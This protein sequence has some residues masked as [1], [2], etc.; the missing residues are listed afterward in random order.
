MQLRK[1]IFLNPEKHLPNEDPRTYEFL[2]FIGQELPEF[3]DEEDVAFVTY[4]FIQEL[5]R[6]PERLPNWMQQEVLFL[7]KNVR[8]IRE[9]LLACGHSN[10]RFVMAYDRLLERHKKIEA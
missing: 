5:G 2:K 6:S 7:C 3:F 10:K 9:L 8:K 4:S 1:L